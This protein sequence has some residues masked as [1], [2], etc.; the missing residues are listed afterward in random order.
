MDWPQYKRNNKK[1][2]HLKGGSHIKPIDAKKK[3]ECSVWRAA[4]DI[5]YNEYRKFL[6][7]VFG[8]PQEE[9]LL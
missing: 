1:W 8:L 4:R 6:N 7:L 9:T 5:E 3:N 2:M